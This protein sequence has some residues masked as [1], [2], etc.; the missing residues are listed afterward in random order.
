MMPVSANR[1]IA[2]KPH[3]LEIVENTQKPSSY[4]QSHALGLRLWM[5]TAVAAEMP[6]ADFRL[7][8]ILV[9]LPSFNH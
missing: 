6:C 1:G 3:P 9:A 5:M 4:W 2:L 8:I 7:A